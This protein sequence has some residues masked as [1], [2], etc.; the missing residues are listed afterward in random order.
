MLGWMRRQGR[1]AFEGLKK[2]FTS[3]PTLIMFDLEKP[4][5]LERD[6]LDQNITNG[7]VG[8]YHGA[9]TEATA[10]SPFFENYSFS[11]DYGFDKIAQDR[12]SVV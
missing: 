6:A 5:T 1:Q 4:M 3:E 7:T 11:R 2:L 10:T 9:I 8:S 12:K